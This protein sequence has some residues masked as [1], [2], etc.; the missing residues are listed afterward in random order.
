MITVM[1]PSLACSSTN[2]CPADASPVAYTELPSNDPPSI[3]LQAT[4]SSAIEICTT[5]A[6]TSDDM[7][8]HSDDIDQAPWLT[9]AWIG[10]LIDTASLS[11]YAGSMR[12]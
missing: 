2:A 4:G 12:F 7:N 8:T 3:L 9:M 1:E 11:W 10:L 5:E 6:E